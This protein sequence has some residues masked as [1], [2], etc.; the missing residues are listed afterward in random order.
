M[1]QPAAL[2][3]RIAGIGGEID[4]RRFELRRVRHHRP[5]PGIE[6]QVQRDVLAEDAAQQAG[7]VA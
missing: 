1:S 5:Q 3:H 7:D 2:R 4:Q 6:V